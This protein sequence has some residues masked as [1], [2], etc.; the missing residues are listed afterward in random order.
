MDILGGLFKPV[1]QIG[2]FHLLS[3]LIVKRKTS[4]VRTTLLKYQIIRFSGLSD[5]GFNEFLHV[6][7]YTCSR[8]SS[9]E[10]KNPS[11]IMQ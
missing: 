2:L 7:T 4:N 8:T 5:H 6:Y 9:V 1:P 11:G 10:D 3:F